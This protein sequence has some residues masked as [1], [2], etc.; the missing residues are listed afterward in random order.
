MLNDYNVDDDYATQLESLTQMV[1]LVAT[2]NTADAQLQI[3]NNVIYQQLVQSVT[4]RW[5]EFVEVS[6]QD[7][8]VATSVW[9]NVVV[10]AVATISLLTAAAFVVSK[11]LGL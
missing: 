6:N 7:M 5:S 2:L 1:Q 11:R 10:Q 3:E 8:E 4:T 9:Q